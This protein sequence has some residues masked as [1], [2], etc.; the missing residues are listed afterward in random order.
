MTAISF[1]R[2]YIIYKPFNLNQVS[3]KT[4]III[5]IVC[6]VK[7]LI[8]ALF[9]VLGWSYYSLEGSYTS[10]GVEWR[11][12]S[13]NLN[14]FKIAIFSGV[15]FIPLILIVFTNVKLVCMVSN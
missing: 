7:G 13:F 1:Q 15:Y 10:C 6:L 5:V 12:Q 2:F 8:W 9:P 4:N 14:S 11:K 3:F